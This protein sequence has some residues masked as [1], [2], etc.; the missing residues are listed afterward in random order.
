MHT[1]HRL[2]YIQFLIGALAI[3]TFILATFNICPFSLSVF[4][5]ALLN[6]TFALSA[7]YEQQYPNFVL[8]LG[9][10]IAF[11]IAGVIIMTT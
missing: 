5:I 6:F 8:S 3:I 7:F 11:S 1:N 2:P 9:M 4:S 10:G